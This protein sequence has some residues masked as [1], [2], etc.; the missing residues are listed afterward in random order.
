MIPKPMFAM[1]HFSE[2]LERKPGILLAP[3][4]FDLALLNF[5]RGLVAGSD[6]GVVQRLVEV[7]VRCGLST[8]LAFTVAESREILHR[9]RVHLIVCVDRLVD[10]GYE[11]ILMAADR[12]RV[13]V[14]LIVVSPTGEWPDFLRAIDAGAFDYMA[15]PPILGELP[16]VI[17]RALRFQATGGGIPSDISSLPKGDLQ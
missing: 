1:E 9:Q 16:R 8:L 10:G 7:M 17:R 13:K 3:A 15:Y 6:E 11:A 5:P 2:T 14:P 12:T 4:P